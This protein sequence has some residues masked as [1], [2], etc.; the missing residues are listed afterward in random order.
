[1]L[2]VVYQKTDPDDAYPVMV[3]VFL[4]KWDAESFIKAQKVPNYFSIEPVDKVWSHWNNIREKLNEQVYR[5]E[6]EY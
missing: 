6:G 5:Y 1:M 3:A 4:M 2:Y